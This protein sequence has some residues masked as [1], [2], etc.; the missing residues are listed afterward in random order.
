MFKVQSTSCYVQSS[1]RFALCSRCKVQGTSCYVRNALHNLVILIELKHI[2]DALA[3][4]RSHLQR[5]HR[6]WH[7]LACLDGVHR[8]S[9]DANALSQLLLR[10]AQDGTL[11]ANVIL[12]HRPPFSFCAVPIG[13]SQC[14]SGTGKSARTTQTTGRGRQRGTMCPE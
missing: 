3:E 11:H 12:H 14:R 6:R 9:R 8:L 1:K 4:H 5:K 7:I 2:V 13:I 10:H